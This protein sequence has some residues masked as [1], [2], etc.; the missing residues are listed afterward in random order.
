MGSL[1]DSLR[2][3]ATPATPPQ[4]SRKARCCRRVQFTIDKSGNQPSCAQTQHALG[5]LYR[6]DGQGSL[7]RSAGSVESRTDGAE[8]KPQNR[9]DFI[10][11]QT[12]EI[13][14]DQNGLQVRPQPRNGLSHLSDRLLHEQFALRALLVARHS[15]L[16]ASL[17]ILL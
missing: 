11:A 14:Q 2:F 7:Q 17:E 5:F 9:R 6:Q 3:P 15:I 16:F 4:M 13:L 10:I 12:L 8:A 1:S